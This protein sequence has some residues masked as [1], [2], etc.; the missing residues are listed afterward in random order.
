MVRGTKRALYYSFLEYAYFF[1]LGWGLL[2]VTIR[3]YRVGLPCTC[4]GE[5]LSEEIPPYFRR[6]V[7]T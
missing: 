3:L 5:V 7:C 1:H 2:S 6:R 4:P